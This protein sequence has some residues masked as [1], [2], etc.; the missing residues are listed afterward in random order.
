LHFTEPVKITPF[1]ALAILWHSRKI[2]RRSTHGN[3]SI[4]RF[5]RKRSSQ[6]GL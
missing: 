3:P 6:I 4:G 5:K 2:L 1:G